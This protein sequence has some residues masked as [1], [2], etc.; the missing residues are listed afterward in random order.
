MDPVIEEELELIRKTTSYEKTTLTVDFCRNHMHN[1][2]ALYKL[3][4][5]L[6]DPLVRIYKEPIECAI[7]K[8]VITTPIKGSGLNF[9]TRMILSNKGSAIDCVINRFTIVPIN[10]V[11]VFRHDIRHEFT[12][13]ELDTIIYI[14]EFV[15]NTILSSYNRK[16][17]CYIDEQRIIDS[18]RL[19]IKQKGIFNS[20]FTKGWTMFM[21]KL[22]AKEE[23]RRLS[24]KM[25]IQLTTMSPIG[26]LFYGGIEYQRVA[27]STMYR[28]L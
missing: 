9:I 10:P 13:L 27:A 17:I 19:Y 26:P 5:I 2:P 24:K 12:D 8:R 15:E 25:F 4:E 14:S 20:S 22:K 18:T 6:V 28:Q 7:C 16:M 23:H 3:Q 11:H 21:E 1:G